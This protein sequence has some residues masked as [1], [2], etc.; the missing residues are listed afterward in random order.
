MYTLIRG[1]DCAKKHKEQLSHEAERRGEHARA[2][3]THPQASEHGVLY[4]EHGGRR[5]KHDSIGWRSMLNWRRA[6][7]GQSAR[8]ALS[9]RGSASTTTLR[10]AS[11]RAWVGL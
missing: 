8:C 6:C 11:M 4:V 10:V 1:S 7:G 5:T 3:A 2:D 9:R